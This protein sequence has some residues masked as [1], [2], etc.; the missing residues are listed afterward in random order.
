MKPNRACWMGLVM[1]AL[2]LGACQGETETPPQDIIRAIKFVVVEEPASGQ[3]RRLPGVVEASDTS[4]LS[5]Q[6]GGNVAVLPVELG[7]SV[8]EG[9]LIAALDDQPYRLQVQ[10]SRAELGEAQANL[11]ER[12]EFHTS[13]ETLFRGGWIAR[14]AF[15]QSLASFQ[16]AQNQVAAAQARL[17]LAQRDLNNARLLAPF[18]GLIS[19]KRVD[20]FQDV[21]AGQPVVL[22]ESQGQLTVDVLMPETILE[23]AP[24]GADVV[25]DLP[26]QGISGL[27]GTVTE[28]GSRA[29]TANAFPVSMTLDAPPDGVRSGMAAEV[30][31]LRAE[32]VGADAPQAFLLPLSA[33]LPGADSFDAFVFRFDRDTST[34]RR[35]AVNSRDI[36]DNLVEVVG[37]IQPGDI[38]A[39]AGAEFLSDGQRVTLWVPE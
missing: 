34:V 39:A 33:L 11:R 9:D 30:T 26:A 32:G 19:E 24:L 18:P 35:L 38:I 22:L 20:A 29:T 27:T 7:D 15:D 36:R 37:P 14:T 6:V 8:Q 17:D 2:V 25:I 13:Q 1:A 10:A 31:F 4:E 28:V 5:F 23:F 3:A 12:R 21:A 16:S